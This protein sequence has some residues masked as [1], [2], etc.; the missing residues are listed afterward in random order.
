MKIVEVLLQKI[1]MYFCL[2]C[3]LLVLIDVSMNGC[4]ICGGELNDEGSRE[5]SVFWRSAWMS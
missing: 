2:C 1:L 3:E 4:A 5:A